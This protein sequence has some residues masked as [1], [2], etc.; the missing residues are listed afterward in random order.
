MECCICMESVYQ[1]DK[2]KWDGH[3]YHQCFTC[4][5]GLICSNC[6]YEGEVVECPVCRTNWDVLILKNEIVETIDS[7]RFYEILGDF[8]LTPELHKIICN[9]SQVGHHHHY[10]E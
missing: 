3:T 2:P 8:G 1:E 4:N 9:N 7:M 5:D 10:E 6:K